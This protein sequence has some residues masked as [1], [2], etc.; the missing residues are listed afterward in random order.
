MID[1]G[2]GHW[3]RWIVTIPESRSCS[4]TKRPL[5]ACQL[6]QTERGS[7][8][9]KIMAPVPPEISRQSTLFDTDDDAFIASEP[10]ARQTTVRLMTAL[11][12]IRGAIDSGNYDQILKGVAEGVSANLCEAVAS[13]QPAGDQAQLHVR[14]T[15]SSSR[16]RLPKTIE[17]VIGFSQTAFEIVRESGAS[18]A[19]S[20]RWLASESRGASSI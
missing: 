7:F 13:M 1:W 18:C 20:C 2:M 9:A 8:V 15:C 10:F 14:M 16:P 5:Q 4:T 6:G 11:G 3:S 17:S 12:H 19:K